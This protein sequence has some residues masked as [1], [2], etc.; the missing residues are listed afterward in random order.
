VG[1]PYWGNMYVIHWTRKRERDMWWN[2]QIGS[3]R[4]I[5]A[6]AERK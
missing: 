4:G 3:T 1:D 5:C 6:S 2:K